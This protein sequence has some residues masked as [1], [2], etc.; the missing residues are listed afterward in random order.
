MDVSRLSSLWIPVGSPGF[1]GA[2][3]SERRRVL[4][5]RFGPDGWRWAH[6]VRGAVVAFEVA[7]HEYEASYHRFLRANPDL[8]AFLVE[9]CGNVYDTGVDNVH[10]DRYDQPHTEMNHYQ[11]IAVRRVV[12]SLIDDVDWPGVTATDVRPAHL[13]DFGT[14]E[15]HRLPR[16][17]GFRG[18]G[19]LQIRDPLSPGYCLSPAVVPV[20]DPLLVTTLPNVV[21]WYHHEG[22]AHLSVE[23]FWQMSKVIEVR[24][25]RFVALGP[26]RMTPLADL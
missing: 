6:V 3:K 18:Q 8:V 25:D 21:E 24:Y 13:I 22:C 4:D 5:A 17:A 9:E 1:S 26:G 10:D 19:L 14:G 2:A 12:A 16:A 11:D 7:I 20:H 15:V 23:A